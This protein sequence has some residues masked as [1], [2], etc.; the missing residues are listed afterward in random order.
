MFG[1]GGYIAGLAVV[2]A[3]YALFQTANTTS[4]MNAAAQDRRGVTSALLGLARN[5]GLITGASAMGAVFAFGSRG[6]AG[7]GLGAG[8]GTGLQVTFGVAT[9]LAGF[10]LAIAVWGRSSDGAR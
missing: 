1:I 9:V 3:G 10:A 2:T 5:L 6:V 8:G 7:L 4:V